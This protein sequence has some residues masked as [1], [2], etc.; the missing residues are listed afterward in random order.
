VIIFFLL[1]VFKA[2]ANTETITATM[3]EGIFATGL[4]VVLLTTPESP[5]E[6]RV[7]SLGVYACFEEELTTT[8]TT[9]AQ[10]TTTQKTTTQFTSSATTIT[11]ELTTTRPTTPQIS[12]Y[13]P[14]DKRLLT[15]K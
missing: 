8:T 10:Q 6:Y 14:A 11:T 4:K 1:Q 3:P 5:A 7:D 2:N 15:A 13:I 9:P 12:E